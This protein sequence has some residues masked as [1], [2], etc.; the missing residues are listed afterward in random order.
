MSAQPYPHDLPAPDDAPDFSRIRRVLVTKLRYHGDVLLTSPVFTVLKA[1]YPHLEIDALVYRETAPML[2]FHPG[3]DTVHCVDKR[4]VRDGPVGRLRAELALHRRPRAREYDLLIHLTEHWRG[5]V[6]KR[7]LGI[8]LAVTAN[9]RRRSSRFWRT[10]FTHF[11]PV[12]TAPRHKAESHLDALRRLG[13]HPRTADQKRL[14]LGIDAAAIESLQSKLAARGAAAAGHVVI[15]PT[16]RFAYK[17][18]TT[19][20]MA[21]LID[22]LHAAGE[23]VVITCA[24][25]LDECD[26]VERI[27]AACR[28]APVSLAGALSLNELAECIR[29]AKLFIGVDSAPMH[30]ASAVGVPVV[31]LFGPTNQ[32]VWGPWLVPHRIVSSGA[33][34]QPC[35]LRGCGDG[36]RSDC[37][38]DLQP[39]DVWRAATGLLESAP[40]VL[41]FPSSRSS[42]EP[43]R[44]R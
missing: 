42:V 33:S 29:A 36:L 27:V 11:Y 30:M 34:C 13:V 8:P 9:Y 6:L 19:Q 39:D 28:F 5:P 38:T 35:Q 14:V 44:H 17:A 21:E 7:L 3:V 41:P 24:P 20:G 16:S 40:C 26:S 2:A 23:R 43:I 4:E 31:S 25:N 32:G 37:M 12:P 18:W 10:S 1:N 22:R 15:H